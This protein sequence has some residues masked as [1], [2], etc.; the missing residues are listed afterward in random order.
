[1]DCISKAALYLRVST[2]EQA[3]EG[4][5]ISAQLETLKQYCQ[6]YHIQIYDIYED[7]GISGKDTVNRPGLQRLLSEAE[8][9]AFNMV[10]VWKIS[11]LSRNLKDLLLIMDKFEQK[12]IVFSSYSEKF[13]T[14][15]PVGRMTLQLLG[16]I[17]EFERNTIIDNV[18][19]GLQEYARKGGKTGT[20]LG[21]DS[22]NRQL[23]VNP[24]E[25]AV[26]RMIYHLYGEEQRSIA[27]IAEHLN[28]S[29]F[30]T[31]RGKPFRKD[32]IA[33]IL[34]NPVYI[35]LNR[36]QTRT[37]N[38]YY[39]EGLH[40]PIIHKELWETVQQLRGGNKNTRR[41][42]AQTD[43]L[44]SGKL[45]CPCCSKPLQGSSSLAKGKTYRY[46]RCKGCKFS[47][48]AEDIEAAAMTVLEEK[49]P[50]LQREA[51]KEQNLRLQQRKEAYS[52]ELN[53]N[54]LLLDKYVLLLEK[55]EL[56]ENELA[57][58]R[59]KQ[60]GQKL[61]TLRQKLRELE[62]AECGYDSMG[63]STP[64]V[65]R[66]LLYRLVDSVELHQDGTL[67]RLNMSP[68]FLY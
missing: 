48:R 27:Y 29:G 61:Q 40:P 59:I 25:A 26:V 57:S 11:R 60:L 55:Q 46:Y 44:L 63:Y 33:F 37:G 12:N 9:G 36:H 20:V 10:L 30:Y 58:A 18:K 64:R 15:T 23:A 32:S 42:S 8:Q 41:N 28:Q 43:F 1:L 65:D 49:L 34:G 7:P 4:Q 62:Q 5:S 56:V 38:E 53:K 17:A 68:S 14:S 13:D 35:G 39:A 3:N 52:Q 47:C 31:K 6:L 66:D 45:S 19:L 24:R 21:Y 22:S 54:T 67:L 16:S 2:E 51:A 50:H